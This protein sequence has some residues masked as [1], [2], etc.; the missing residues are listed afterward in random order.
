[1]TR[2]D[3]GGARAGGLGIGCAVGRIA[4]VH[5]WLTIPGGSEKVVLELLELLPQAELFTSVYD[6]APWP[7]PIADREVHASF[8]DRLPGARTHYPK[9]L[10]LMNRAFESLRP[11][12]L[13]PRRVLEPLVREE[14]ASRRPGRCTSATA[15]RRCATP[16]SRASSPARPGRRSD[17]A[18]RTA[19]ARG[20]AATTAWPRSGP[21]ASSPTPRTSRRGSAS[22][23]RRD[24]RVIHPP[25]DVERFLDVPRATGDYYLVLGRVVPYKRVDLAVAACARARAAASRSSARAARSTPRA[26]PRARGT[27]FLG[28]VPDDELADAA[29]RRARRCCSRARRTSASSRS[30]RRRPACR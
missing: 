28:H 29:R 21:T 18:S 4:L 24:A 1:M 9:L 3:D 30:R 10:P 15:T 22:Y 17:G 11:R 19:A 16:G 14:R 25:V 20:C 5:D 27:E 26:P 2:H 23:Y 6:P 7:A 13:R 12:R 8:L